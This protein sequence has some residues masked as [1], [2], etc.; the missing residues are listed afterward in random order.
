MKQKCRHAIALGLQDTLAKAQAKSL[1]QK[2]K[3]VTVLQTPKAF[4]RPQGHCITDT[5]SFG[6]VLVALTLVGAILWNFD[7]FE[8]TNR[9]LGFFFVNMVLG[10]TPLVWAYHLLY[11]Y[12][13]RKRVQKGKRK[14]L[15]RV[16]AIDHA[17]KVLQDDAQQ[18]ALIEVFDQEK[19]YLL[20]ANQ[21]GLSVRPNE[22]V[23]VIWHSISQLCWIEQSA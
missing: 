18:R 15:G 4:P 23:T 21:P 11:P 14:A 12:F 16:V 19:R 17:G 7:Q 1:G 2:H 8:W 20:V 5:L 22:T 3:G 6:G 13:D 9:Q 10:I